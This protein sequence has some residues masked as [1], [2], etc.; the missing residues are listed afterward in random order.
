M[1]RR[2]AC[3]H[4][5]PV[6]VDG[7]ALLICGDKGVGKTTLQ[8][9]LARGRAS[10]MA[11]DRVYCLA[12]REGIHCYGHPARA[13]LMPDTFTRFGP[14][15]GSYDGLPQDGPVKVI[16]TITEVAR[17]LGTTVVPQAPHLMTVILNRSRD[18]Y[19]LTADARVKQLEPQWLDGSPDPLAG[20]WLFRAPDAVELAHRHASLAARADVVA[21]DAGPLLEMHPRAAVGYVRELAD[22]CA[23]AT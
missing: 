19:R 6:V 13:S 17:R 1:L 22:S 15:L 20:D 21:L 3:L 23:K 12:E 18:T 2:A 5:A 10:L 9:H 8:F 14:H 4:A 11:A 16:M 7:S